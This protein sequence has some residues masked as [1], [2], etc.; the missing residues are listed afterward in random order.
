MHNASR[1]ENGVLLNSRVSCG[2]ACSVGWQ[3]V[4]ERKDDHRSS[5]IGSRGEHSSG[6]RADRF[7]LQRILLI[8]YRATL[9]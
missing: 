9:C 3:R 6:C 1:G 4:A 7:P 2:C 5:I 8:F